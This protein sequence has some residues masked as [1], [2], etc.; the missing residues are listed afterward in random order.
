MLKF[1]RY[2]LFIT[3]LLIVAACGNGKKKDPNLTYF[4]K[5]SEYNDYINNQ[6]NEVNRLWNACLNK[7][8]DSV[9]VYKQLDSLKGAC[10]SSIS[11]MNKLADYKGD[12]L[13][14][15]A[16]SEYFKYMLKTA[17]GSFL[18]A[19]QIGLMPDVSDSLYFR[20]TAIGN[21]IGADKDSCIAD[22]KAAQLNFIRLN[23]K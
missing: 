10:N 7:M 2:I 16:A 17:N 8:D 21:Q 4:D 13:Y 3:F 1:N 6:F 19:I 22:I 15:H 18:E 20:F 12:T 11:N 5:A 14:K 9:L 23:E